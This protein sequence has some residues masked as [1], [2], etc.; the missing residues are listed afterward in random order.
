H[1]YIRV[2]LRQQAKLTTKV[3]GT[4]DTERRITARQKPRSLQQASLLHSIR[5]LRPPE[6]TG[7]LN[8]A[9]PGQT[10]ALIG[11]AS[12]SRIQRPQLRI[13]DPTVKLNLINPAK[14]IDDR[15]TIN[16]LVNTGL[17]VIPELTATESVNSSR[18]SRDRQ[19]HLGVVQ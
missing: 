11:A 5:D 2:D 6:H 18:G 13:H 7:D 3:G 12:S 19:G 16:R 8:L 1:R 9:I 10:Q 15:D 14:V 4:R 17:L